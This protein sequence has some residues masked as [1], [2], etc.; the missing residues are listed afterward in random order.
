MW[1]TD[2]NQQTFGS[3]DDYVQPL[4]IK[5]FRKK[6][7]K[8]N[9]FRTK[10]RNLKAFVKKFQNICDGKSH[11]ASKTRCLPGDRWRS[12]YNNRQRGPLTQSWSAFLGLETFLPCQLLF[13]DSLS[14]GIPGRCVDIATCMVSLHRCRLP[15]RCF[16]L[17]TESS[18]ISGCSEWLRWPLLCCINYWVRWIIYAL[19]G[20]AR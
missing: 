19:R 1:I 8:I 14:L 11:A 4:Q 17:S 20:V 5:V 12:W 2:H 9:G 6:I 15:W 10:V 16:H 18:T 7:G 3:C 13:C